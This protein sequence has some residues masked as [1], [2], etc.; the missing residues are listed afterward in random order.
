VTSKPA[1]RR[2]DGGQTS[3]A[4]VPALDGARGIAIALVLAY[5]LDV[6]GVRGGFLGVDLFF[7]L[8]GFLITTLLLDEHRANGR[9]DFVQFWYR[10]ARRLLPA[11]FLLIGVVVVAA[12]SATPLEK[13]PLRWDLLASLGYAANWRFIIAGQSYFDEFVTVSPV[14]HL[15][16]LSIEEQFYAVWPLIIAGALAWIAARSSKR[17]PTAAAVLA[18]VAIGSA[19][20]MAATYREADPSLAY[21]STFARA[22]ELLVGALAAIALARIPALRLRIG[23]HAGAIA[24]GGLVA[25]LAAAV[26]TSDTE[27][28]YYHGGSL[29]FSIFAAALIV[30]LVA[31]DQSTSVVHRAMRIRPLIWLGA[32]SYGV[33]LWHW[34][35]TVWLQPRPG[36]EGVGLFAARLG[37]TLLIASASF[38]LVERPIRRGVVG[39][40]RLRPAIALIGAVVGFAVLSS[41]TVLATRGWEPPPAFLS[42]DPVLQVHRVEHS[43][44]TVG[45]IGDSVALSLYPGMWREGETRGITTVSAA[46]AGCGVGDALRTEDDGTLQWKT[47]RCAETIPAL[48]SELIREYDPDVVFWHSQRDRQDIRLGDQN[49][50]AP[51]DGWREVLFADWDRTLER[52]RAGGAVV[53]V[54]PPLHAQGTDPTECA[55]PV[56]LRT[57]ECVDPVMSNGA[58]RSIYFEWAALHREDDFVL[59]DEADRLCPAAPCPPTL[60]GV[61]LRRDLIHLS[62]GGARLLSQWLLDGLPTGTLPD[63]LSGE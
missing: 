53:V 18:G 6:P 10:R 3:L 35:I 60:E 57:P 56:G 34:P 4:Y 14:R 32:I 11:L 52:L 63:Q 7:V 29:L 50:E 38:I 54:I 17:W 58:L 16:S 39:R 33:Y 48:Q 27:A 59:M 21:Y 19:V 1:P 40:I 15:W 31:G 28:L 2:G 20:V 47:E 5:H 24:A 41:G 12:G 22:H 13:G 37:L 46:V 44:A 61:N 49:L 62:T 51:S 45:I 8:S 9:I 55:G 36:L 26:V 30:A 25:V 43:T 23:A 42:E